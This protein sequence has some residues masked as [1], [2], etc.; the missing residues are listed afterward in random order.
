MFASR[1]LKNTFK[2]H[3]QLFKRSRLTDRENKLVIT[4]GEWR[5]GQDRGEEMRGTNYWG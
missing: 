2:N 1:E 5:E 3:C 4:S